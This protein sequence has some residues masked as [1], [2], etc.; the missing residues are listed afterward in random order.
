MASSSPSTTPSNKKFP[1]TADFSF[2]MEATYRKLVLRG[3]RTIEA[4]DLSLE[5]H[6]KRILENTSDFFEAIDLLNALQEEIQYRL[7]VY[8]RNLSKA[9]RNYFQYLLEDYNEKLKLR[10]RRDLYR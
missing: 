4:V 6:Y 8:T 5:D 1:H 9:S 10:L 7:K 2:D 3:R